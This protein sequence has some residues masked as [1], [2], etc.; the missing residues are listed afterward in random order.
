MPERVAVV[1]SGKVQQHFHTLHP[2]LQPALHLLRSAKT[3]TTNWPAL[4]EHL[5][6]ASVFEVKQYASD[7]VSSCGH[8]WDATHMLFLIHPDEVWLGVVEAALRMNRTMAIFVAT[9]PK[10]IRRVYKRDLRFS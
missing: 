9:S 8:L 2:Q 1:V 6:A 4:R 7:L 5:P 3:V 10:E